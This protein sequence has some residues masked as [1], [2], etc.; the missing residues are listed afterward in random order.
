M[1]YSCLKPRDGKTEFKPS[2]R[3]YP[4]HRDMYSLFPG[5]K[6]GESTR[7]FVFRVAPQCIYM[8]SKEQ[9]MDTDG[10]WNIESAPYN[11]NF[12][13]GSA[14]D[15]LLRLNPR[16]KNDKQETHGAV[17][18]YL[19]T[20]RNA[21]KE[22]SDWPTP[23]EIRNTAVFDWLAKNS[24][25]F[26][27]MKDSVMVELQDWWKFLNEKTGHNIEGEILDLRG[28]L[29]ITDP[30]VFKASLIKGIGSLGSFGCG[31]LMVR[32]AR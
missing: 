19:Y 15:F 14:W 25:G 13:V 11:P 4:I 2:K 1:Y 8:L 31:L 24:R 5:M 9:P 21:F 18:N 20:L 3:I 28:R 12:I 16:I 27:V 17:Q 6:P 29:T 22:K 7:S 30:E 23:S 26:S 10:K 32:A